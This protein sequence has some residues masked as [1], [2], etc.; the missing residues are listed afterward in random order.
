MFRG[1]NIF[2]RWGRAGASSPSPAP[3][4]PDCH[5]CHSG[6]QHVSCCGCSGV[7]CCAGNHNHHMGYRRGYADLNNI[8]P[9]PSTGAF[10]I[11]IVLDSSSSMSS[12]STN[13]LA[14]LNALIKEQQSITE[15][16]TTFTL[17]KFA[18]NVTTIREN[19]PLERI[20]PLSDEDY[21]PSGMTAL[22]DGIGY[23]INRFRNERDVL[24][25]IITDGQEN[26]SKKFNKTYVTDKIN[27]KK[28]Y[29]NWE[30]IYLS[31]DLDTFE[32]GNTLG[33]APTDYTT[34][35]QLDCNNMAGF[36]KD[37]VSAAIKNY[38][39]TGQQACQYLNM[40]A[41]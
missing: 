25:V 16:P 8:A 30:Y 10:K 1:N 36:M 19:E 35:I 39:R 9:I 22:Y 4:N 17:I 41:N 26:A 7:K 23:A 5:R 6:E 38:R 18:D 28:K 31:S 14:S 33:F 29:S 20:R 37:N 13:M 32:Q 40:Q 15:K 34:N 12:I 21:I 27:E 11:V 3:L 2:G 24:M